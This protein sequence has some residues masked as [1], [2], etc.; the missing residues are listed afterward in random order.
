[1]GLANYYFAN[2]TAELYLKGTVNLK[3][4]EKNVNMY[5]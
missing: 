3:K 4:V 2:E 1:M 5:I